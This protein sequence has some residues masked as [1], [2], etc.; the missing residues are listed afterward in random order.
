[1]VRDG[2]YSNRTDFIRVPLLRRHLPPEAS[3]AFRTARRAPSTWRQ[4]TSARHAA[5]HQRRR[6]PPRHVGA[7]RCS[8]ERRTAPARPA[9]RKSCARFDHRHRAGG[10]EVHR[11]TIDPVVPVNEVLNAGWYGR[12]GSISGTGFRHHELVPS[13]GIEYRPAMDA[14]RYHCRPRL[15]SRYPRTE[16]SWCPCRSRSRRAGKA[17]LLRAASH[18]PWIY[19]TSLS[20]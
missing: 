15:W 1:M 7:S 5:Q 17:G 19:R 4:T 2:F 9:R 20:R 18:S 6:P 3:S 13:Q 14:K 10:R 12:L 16:R 11:L 8:I